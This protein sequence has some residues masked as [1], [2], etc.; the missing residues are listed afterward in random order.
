MHKENSQYIPDL[1]LETGGFM[2]PVARRSSVPNSKTLIEHS[3]EHEEHKYTVIS[4]NQFQNS[5][6]EIMLTQTQFVTEEALRNNLNI[7][8]TNLDI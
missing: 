2:M 3:E 4:V 8:Y 5:H 6:R 1:R 7:A